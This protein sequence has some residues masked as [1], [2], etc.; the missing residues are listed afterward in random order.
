MSAA[1]ATSAELKEVPDTD[2]HRCRHVDAGGLI[3]ISKG[4]ARITNDGAL[5]NYICELKMLH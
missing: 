4:S 2:A 1:P 5:N 3:W